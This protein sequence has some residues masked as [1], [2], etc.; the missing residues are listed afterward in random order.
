MRPHDSFCQEFLSTH[1]I[2]A[3]WGLGDVPI[4]C[5]FLSL[6]SWDHS[7]RHEL[8]LWAGFQSRTVNFCDRDCIGNIA[9]VHKLRAVPYRSPM[10]LDDDAFG[11]SQR[12]FSFILIFIF[13]LEFT[14]KL[15]L[16]E[17]RNFKLI[18]RSFYSMN[19]AWG[20]RVIFLCHI[21]PKKGFLWVI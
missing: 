10:F 15:I 14:R 21:R 16:L 6:Y 11:H 20:S 13:E 5:P 18:A 1:H 4:L 7:S 8:V 3:Y 2:D 19:T 12:M 9:I 17:V